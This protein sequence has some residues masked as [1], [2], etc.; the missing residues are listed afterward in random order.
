M[1]IS[2]PSFAQLIK[3]LNGEI[4]SLDPFILL[5]IRLFA[6]RFYSKEKFDQLSINSHVD[7]SVDLYEFSPFKNGQNLIKHGISFKQTLKCEDFGCLAVDYHDPKQDEKRSIIFSVYSSKHHNSILPLGVDFHES[8]PKICMTIATNRLNKIRFI[9]SRLFKID[10]CRKHLKSTFRDIHAENKDARE[11][12]INSCN[13]I[14]D[15]AIEI[16]RQD[17]GSST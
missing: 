12:F 15:K 10:D 4:K 1:E 3:V 11:K 2:K 9:S 16:T 13:S 5:D 17:D 7:S 14:L 8:D 6:L